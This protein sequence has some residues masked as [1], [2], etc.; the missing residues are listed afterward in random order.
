MRVTICAYLQ[1][2]ITSSGPRHAAMHGMSIHS[3]WRDIVESVLQRVGRKSEIAEAASARPP[4]VWSATS[5]T[6]R[7]LA[8]TGLRTDVAR[9][10]RSLRW[11]VSNDARTARAS[12]EQRRGFTVRSTMRAAD[13]A[14]ARSH[15]HGRAS[16]MMIA[17]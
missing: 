6:A 16:S 5:V 13:C 1:A 11:P 17:V 7:A 4:R 3:R 8:D 14:R 10:A 9:G 2:L 12:G 15:A